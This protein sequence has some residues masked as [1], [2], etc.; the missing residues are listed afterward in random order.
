MSAVIWCLRHDANMVCSNIT[1]GAS[2]CKEYDSIVSIFRHFNVSLPNQKK[3]LGKM[4][5]H[6]IRH[7]TTKWMLLHFSG[8]LSLSFASGFDF[9]V[10]NCISTVVALMNLYGFEKGYHKCSEIITCFQSRTLFTSIAAS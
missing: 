1:K 5:T 3:L 7:K 6:L 2:P 4:E 9:L 10:A 8:L